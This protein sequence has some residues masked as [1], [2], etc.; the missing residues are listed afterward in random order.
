MAKKKNTNI[1][2]MVKAKQ[3]P[4]QM[5]TKK[6]YPVDHKIIWDGSLGSI[7]R[8]TRKRT[9]G[10]LVE[11]EGNRGCRKVVETSDSVLQEKLEK[12]GYVAEQDN[13]VM[14]TAGQVKPPS[15]KTPGQVEMDNK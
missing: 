14:H 12:R 13:K 15:I 5:G 4:G 9:G 7:D 1:A 6:R 2:D 10:V 11:A 8:K 3:A